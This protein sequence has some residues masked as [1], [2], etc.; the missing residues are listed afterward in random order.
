[1]TTFVHFFI[2]QPL[3]ASLTVIVLAIA[4]G[5]FSV[6]VVAMVEAIVD[7]V[8]SLRAWIEKRRQARA[9]TDEALRLVDQRQINESIRAIVQADVRRRL[10]LASR[11]GERVAR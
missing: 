1:M 11:T 2:D 8:A 5:F 7:G 10:E 3:L 6:V 4:I 9:V